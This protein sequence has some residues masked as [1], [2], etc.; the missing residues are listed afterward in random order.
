MQAFQPN[1]LVRVAFS[2]TGTAIIATS[3][4]PA[5]PQNRAIGGVLPHTAV[6]PLIAGQAVIGKRSGSKRS[7]ISIIDPFAPYSFGDTQT[8]CQTGEGNT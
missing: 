8:Y 4:L 3:M 6:D 7:T 1:S 2:L 5:P